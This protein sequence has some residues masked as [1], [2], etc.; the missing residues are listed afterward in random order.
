MSKKTPSIVGTTLLIPPHS[1]ITGSNP[2]SHQDDRYVA[3]LFTSHGYG[4]TVDPPDAILKNTK[5]AL[6]DLTSQIDEMRKQKPENL[7]GQCRAVRINSGKFGV[8]WAR[9]KKVLEERSLDMVVVRPEV[10]ERGEEGVS[11]RTWK[12]RKK[13]GSVR[14]DSEK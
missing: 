6:D 9:T 2:P 4:K 10:G 1:C 7:L 5:A 8:P 13:K 11:K 12:G 14:R 3:C